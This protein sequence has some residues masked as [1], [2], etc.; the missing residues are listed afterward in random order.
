MGAMIWLTVQELMLETFENNDGRKN[1]SIFIFLSLT[2]TFMPDM[3]NL[4]CDEGGGC[5]FLSLSI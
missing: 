2:V 5:L 4:V 1:R 3:Y